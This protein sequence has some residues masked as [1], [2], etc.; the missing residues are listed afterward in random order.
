MSLLML[1][2]EAELLFL[3]NPTASPVPLCKRTWA[4]V[5]SAGA[6]ISKGFYEA[7][8]VCLAEKNTGP[9]NPCH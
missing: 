8:V 6:G 3:D 4:Q 2:C 5:A 7:D 9:Q 1:E